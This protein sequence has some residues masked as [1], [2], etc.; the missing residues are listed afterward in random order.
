MPP[1]FRFYDGAELWYSLGRFAVAEAADMQNRGAHA[2]TYVVA[3]LARG[4]SPEAARSE[5]AAIAARLAQVYPKTNSDHGVSV[6]TVGEDL[7][8]GVR[9]SLLVLLGA[10]AFVLL[11]ACSNVANL[12]AVRASGRTREV[13]IQTA[14]GAQRSRL[15][16]KFLAESL[17]LA[18]LGGI[19]ALALTGLCIKL[20]IAY[21]P[22]NIPRLDQVSID[23]RVLLFTAGISLIAGLLFGLVPIVQS[24]S[25]ALQTYLR[26]GTG[27]GTGAARWH[28]LRQILVAAEVAASLI[29]LV[30]ASLM[31]QSFWNLINS[32]PGFDPR[33]VLLLNISLP[34]AKYP[35][36]ADAGRFYQRLLEGVTAL[37]GV[38]QAGVVTP[39]PMS[40]SDRS[41][42]I[43]LLGKDRKNPQDEVHVD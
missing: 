26:E 36:Q 20:A 7:V 24:W 19:A 33:G 35:E 38:R 28:R 4:R 17:L 37:P 21:N 34:D 23:G 10:V 29:L 12:L 42:E 16:R 27:G 39:L 43:V 31:I 9:H 1:D 2:G 15:V 41:G 40:G 30:G 8:G 3:R 14:L 22:G 18:L 11:I 13:A 32:S 5:M 6:V 25:L